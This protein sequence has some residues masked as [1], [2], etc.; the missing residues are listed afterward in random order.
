[1]ASPSD[2]WAFFLLAQELSIRSLLPA[3]LSPSLQNGA[4]L[5]IWVVAFLYVGEFIFPWRKNQPKLREG[6]WLD[7]F[8][9]LFFLLI[10]VGVIGVP[11]FQTVQLML[12]HASHVG[13]GLRL[14]VVVDLGELPLWSR[15]AL[16]F[17]YNDLLNYLGHRLLHRSSFLWTFHKIHHSSKRLDVLNA[18]RIHWFER[19]FY[20]LFF[21]VPSALIG[22]EAE[23]VFAATV[24][25]VV[26]CT[27]THANIKVP[28]GPL[29]YVLNN[30]Q[31]HLWHHAAEVPAKRNVNYGSALSL[32]DFLFR[33]AYLPDNRSDIELGFAGMEDLPT[34]LWGQQTYPLSRLLPRLRGRARSRS[35]GTD[36]R[37]ALAVALAALAALV[38]VLVVG[39]AARERVLLSFHIGYQQR[40][41][42]LLSRLKTLAALDELESSA[43]ID[44][45]RIETLNRMA[46]LNQ[47]AKF[48]SPPT[49]QLFAQVSAEAEL[50]FKIGKTIMAQL[51]DGRHLTDPKRKILER[52]TENAKMLVALRPRSARSHYLMGMVYVV[53]ARDTGSASE[54]SRAAAS[55]EQVI[56]LHPQ[57]AGAQRALEE[58]RGQ[59]H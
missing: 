6:V 36:R 30:P 40:V 14:S 20:L 34:T 21:Y 15:Y 4:Y 59:A 17:L 22:F 41:N 51:G 9:T 7:A 11:T 31:L 47:T 1:M 27:F 39:E 37:F 45:N 26:L 12:H 55:L 19:I 18:A 54:Y 25:S 29:K 8:Y 24:A 43:L 16:L 5:A 23:Q 38:G 32:W 2:Y 53:R 50:H 28:L 56:A 58:A 13:L 46:Q 10:F 3:L 35:L 44:A 57:H 49:A 42:T 52:A 48:V 33:T